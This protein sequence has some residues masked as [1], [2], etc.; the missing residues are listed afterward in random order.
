MKTKTLVLIKGLEKEQLKDE[1]SEQKI[2]IK[3]L[4]DLK[5]LRKISIEFSMKERKPIRVTSFSEIE[6]GK[7]FVKLY[8]VSHVRKLE[9]EIRSIEELI[10]ELRFQIID[11][12]DM[13][14]KESS[15]SMRTVNHLREAVNGQ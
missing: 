2:A 6:S 3:K 8:L 1:I 5:R 9:E 10:E 12:E 15:D 13:L 14:E 4:D 7:K 11:N